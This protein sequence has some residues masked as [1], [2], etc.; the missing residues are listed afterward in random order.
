MKIN[1]LIFL[2]LPTM[3]ALTAQNKLRVPKV[4]AQL[5]YDSE[6]ILR[7]VDKNGKTMILEHDK[8]R[9]TLSSV[10]PKSTAHKNG[11][12]LQFDSPNLRG[13]KVTYGLIPYGKHTYPTPVYRFDALIDST[14]QTAFLNIRQDLRDGFDHTGWLQSGFGVIGYRLTDA[15]GTIIYEGKQSFGVKGDSIVPRPTILRGPFLSQQTSHQMVMWYETS[16][17]VFSDVKIEGT[18]IQFSSATR[19]KRHECTIT[20][21]Q[22]NTNYRYTIRCDSS[23]MT[24][25]MRT[26][27]NNEAKTAF[28]FAY[29]SDS[30]SGYGGGERNIYGANVKIMER[31][32]ALAHHKGAAFLQFTGDLASGYLNHPDEM[33]LQLTNWIHAVEP[34]WH[35]LPFHV[36]MGNH[37]SVGWK[38]QG[39][40]SVLV[41]GFP[42]ETHSGEAVFNKMF[43]NPLNGPQSEDGAIYDP[44]PTQ[45]NDFPS[46]QGNVYHYRYGNTAMI[47]LN[48][49]Y[50]FAPSLPNILHI[51][52]NLHGYVMDQQLKWLHTTLETFEKD[53][54][55]DHVFVTIH[56][57]PFP[58]GGHRG[59][60]MW[61]DGNN[62]KRPYVAGKPVNK[63]IIERRDE[64]LDLCANR[65]TKVIGFLCG[66][67]HN[68]NRMIIDD[69]T[70][71]YPENWTLPRLKLRR[72]LW[73][74]INGAAGAPFYAQQQTPW[75]AFVKGFTVQNALCFFDIDGKKVSIRVFNPDTLELIDEAIVKK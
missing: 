69:N 62:A 64:I 54:T 18:N 45:D 37:E 6:G 72:P 20:Q 2:L 61:Y 16:E 31:I 41:D 74:V 7:G 17:P 57:P 26:A 43:L 4:Y 36:G 52:G 51:G 24:Y 60:C 56:T 5:Q 66:D 53:N 40:A 63:G 35:Y 34:Y 3:T 44:D 10:T 1:F 21:L 47:V 22:P 14:S 59:D 46:Y 33:N 67:E 23:E 42:Y 32:G 29:A 39:G 9:F 8:A 27:P 11:L 58:N 13:G 68:Y 28:S 65:S 70:P 25:S 73:Q 55:L 12:T 75:S 48:S 71:R 38:A 15:K 50:W 30:R 19:Q 49:N